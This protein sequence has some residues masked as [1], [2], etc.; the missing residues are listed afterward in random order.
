[1]PQ[2]SIPYS[3]HRL[4]WT[5]APLIYF[6]YFTQEGPSLWAPESAVLTTEGICKTANIHHTWCSQLHCTQINT[7]LCLLSL[8][9]L[10]WPEENLEMQNH[11]SKTSGPLLALLSFPPHLPWFLHPCS[12]RTPRIHLFQ[13]PQHSPYKT[14][15]STIITTLC[16]RKP[17]L[18]E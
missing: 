5:V 6:V 14:A 15:H 1:M 11:T 3:S 4:S 10:S 12:I 7:A 2:P 16:P 8:L 13:I 17:C 9:F 18:L